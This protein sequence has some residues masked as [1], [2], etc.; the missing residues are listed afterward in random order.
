M[1][2][3]KNKLKPI[4]EVVENKKRLKLLDGL[5]CDVD[6]DV[7]VTIYFTPSSVYI[8]SRVTV[9]SYDGS[10]WALAWQKLGVLVGYCLP[11]ADLV[12]VQLVSMYNY[13]DGLQS[14]LQV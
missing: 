1:V 7:M 10:C 5:K 8:H 9:I 11:L 2:S 3:Y 12:S 4:L 14:V 13:A 6:Q